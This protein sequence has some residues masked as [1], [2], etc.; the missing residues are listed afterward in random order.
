MNTSLPN[1]LVKSI[2]KAAANATISP[3]TL[4]PWVDEINAY[5]AEKGKFTKQQVAYIPFSPPPVFWDY[6]CKKCK[7]WKEPDSCTTVEGK[8]SPRGYCVIWLP[9]E[10][11]PAFSWINELLRGDW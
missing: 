8:I 2:T 1:L 7:F 3:G 9:P 6:K 4:Q 10:D 11:K 5:V